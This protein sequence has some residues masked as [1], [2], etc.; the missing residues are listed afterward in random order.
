[1]KEYFERLVK[2]K[3]FPGCNYA[4]IHKDKIEINSV[5]NKS[6]IPKIEK[7]NLD[8]LYDLASLTKVLVTNVL[9]SKLLEKHTIK[10]S[11]KVVKYLPKF[12]YD[13]ITIFH[14]LTHTSGLIADVDWEKVNN[15]DQLIDLL[16]K[17][18]LYYSTD[19]D[20]IYSDLNFIFLG[21]IIEKIYNKKLDVIASEEIFNPLNM[22]K[23]SFNPKNKELCAPTEI[24]EKRGIVKGF[25][26]DEK[27]Y[28]MGGVCGSAGVFSNVLDLL[29]FVKMIMNDGMID[30]K[31]FISKKYIDLWFTPFVEGKQ[32]NK[33][34]LG[35]CV[36]KGE[37]TGTKCSDSTISHTGF[38]GN[39]L[40]I[41]REKGLGFIQLSNRIHPT[42]K[43]K[44]LIKK[45]KY[46]ANY[47]YNNIDK[48]DDN[49]N[50]VI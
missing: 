5:G 7:N 9:I 43:N 19:E 10:L 42:R 44:Q 14:L 11:D 24:T 23:T 3:I 32:N 16:Y 12:K 39:T 36:G 50:R 1:M 49:I 13:N 26:H 40:I 31:K 2:Q 35:W 22:N 46:I 29:N 8:T 18:D 20:V 41:D 38:T 47:I 33:R 48:L 27:A 45:R 4:I 34:S 30:G 15:K 28:L 25:V 21:F 37:V 6:L 17:K